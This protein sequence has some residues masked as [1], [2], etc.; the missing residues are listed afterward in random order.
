MANLPTFFAGAVPSDQFPNADLTGG[1]NPGGSNSPGIGINS[2]D[3][4]PKATDWSRDVRDPQNGQQLGQTAAPITFVQG[5]DINDQAA[6]V[7]AATATA[8]DAALQPGIIN[9]T[10]KTVPQDSWAWGTKTVA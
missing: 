5:A 9:R 4:D 1:V 10:G 2:G 6:F 8:P 3:Y 7:Q